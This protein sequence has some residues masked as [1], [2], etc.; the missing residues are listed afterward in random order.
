MS[1]FAGTRPGESPPQF[2]ART[3]DRMPD[4]YP[5][6]TVRGGFNSA[7]AWAIEKAM[8]GVLASRQRSKQRLTA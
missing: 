5:A 7:L 4:D 8:E 6:L 1:S 3:R 2:L